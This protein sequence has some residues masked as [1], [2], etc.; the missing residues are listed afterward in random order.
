LSVQPIAP[1]PFVTSDPQSRKNGNRVLAKGQT[2][3]TVTNLQQHPPRLP[4]GKRADAKKNLSRL[5]KDGKKKRFL[6]G[7]KT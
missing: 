5:E 2:I 3:K 6:E 4:K 7:E 1:Y